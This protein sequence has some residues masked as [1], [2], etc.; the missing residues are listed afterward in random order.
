MVGAIEE[1]SDRIVQIGQ[2]EELAVAC[3]VPTPNEQL[4][5]IWR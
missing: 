4:R 1:V 2:A 5:A 3:T